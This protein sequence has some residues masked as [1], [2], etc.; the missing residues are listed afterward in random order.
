MI[1]FHL[2]LDIYWK[3]KKETRVFSPRLLLVSEAGAFNWSASNL[4]VSG[5]FTSG[6]TPKWDMRENKTKQSTFSMS[7]FSFDIY[8]SMVVTPFLARILSFEIS[9]TPWATQLKDHRHPPAAEGGKTDG[10]QAFCSAWISWG[11]LAGLTPT[12]RWQQSQW[13]LGG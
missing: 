9:K 1:Y 13:L 11:L 4:L 3:R 8:L 6:N 10:R 5:S 12:V 7:V 2:K